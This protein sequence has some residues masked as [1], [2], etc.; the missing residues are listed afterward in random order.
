L[1]G[2]N[3]EGNKVMNDN[4]MW[5]GFICNYSSLVRLDF[6]NS[7]L[8][9][10]TATTLDLTYS[11]AY[12]YDTLIMKEGN[13]WIGF[14][15]DNIPR[16]LVR[17]DFGASLVNIPAVVNLGNFNGAIVNP[18]HINFINKDN[19]WFMFIA[20]VDETLLRLSFGNSLLN[21]P[22]VSNIGNMGGDTFQSADFEPSSD[23]DSV[24]GFMLKYL[25][26]YDPKLFYRVYL[27]DGI[28]GIPT[29]TPLGNLGGLD[30][31]HSFSEFYRVADT[32]YTF[33]TN[34]GSPTLTRLSWTNCSSASIPS[35]TLF[36][37]QAFH[38][39]SQGIYTI[40]LIVDEGLPTQSSICKKI[41]VSCNG[42]VSNFTYQQQFR[43][44]T[45]SNQ[46]SGAT[47]WQLEFGDGEYSVLSDPVHVYAN[48]G[49][50]NVCLTTTNSCTV[51]TYCDTG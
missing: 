18:G 4:G 45:F 16:N 5:Y 32:N 49:K 38:Y 30:R 22:I 24:N 40:R 36:S 47:N 6:G 25:D 1:L 12:A 48:S 8:N 46:S 10:L 35:S 11:F 27:P 14:V 50:Y 26:P 42:P 19:N 33:V 31:P 9:T 20:G 29:A 28:L 3:I 44:F 21:V 7:L 15:D 51:N 41:V 39:D 17:L 37:P 43:T 34:R 13:S 23:C 2:T